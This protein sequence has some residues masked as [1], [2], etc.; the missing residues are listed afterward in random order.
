[1]VGGRGLE[2]PTPC[3]SSNGNPVGNALQSKKIGAGGFE[4]C[5]NGCTR[6][7]EASQLDRLEALA[8]ALRKLPE[9]QRRRF[10]DVLAKQN[11]GE[12]GD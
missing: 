7:P 3:T 4:G 11:E 6:T 1:M 9:D 5:T 12:K 8:D 2:P 10:L